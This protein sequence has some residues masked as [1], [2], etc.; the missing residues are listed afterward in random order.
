[1][2]NQKRNLRLLLALALLVFTSSCLAAGNVYAS[3]GG[4]VVWTQTSN[5][6][7]EDDYSYGV[8]VDSSG[9]F[10]VGYDSSSGDWQW[11]IEKRSLTNGSLIWSQT[12]DPGA[13]NDAA[14]DVASD[15][16]GLFVVGY[17]SSPGSSGNYQWRIEKR[18]LADG[19]LMWSQVSNPSVI[20]DFAYG[21]SIDGSGMYVVGSDNSPG[22]TDHQWRIEKRGLTDGSL[23]PTFG[24]G[25]VI[26]ENP[27]SGGDVA[28]DVTVDGS[29]MY[30]T[31]YD[32]S[33]GSGNS[34]WRIEKRSLTDGSLLWSQT[35]NPSDGY[36][37]TYGVAVDSSG[38]F[39]VGYDSSSGNLQW[40]IE[41]RRL[42]DGTLIWSQTSN[43][44]SGDHRAYGVAVHSSGVYIAGS[45][46]IPG[47]DE[48][49]IERRSA[50]DGTLTSTFGTGGI[51]QEDPSSGADS[52][53]GVAVDNSGVYVVGYDNSPGKSEWRIERR[54]LGLSSSKLAITVF[55]SS[56]IVGSWTS[57]CTV[58]R[59]DEFGNPVT[60]DSTIVNLAST[61]TGTGKKFSE[62]SGGAAVTSITI[63]DGS[64]TKDFY[65]FDDRAGSW[66]IS[67]SAA[68]L[69]SDN[70]P[71]TVSP[72]SGCVIATAAYGS[73]MAP[74]VSYMRHVRDDVIGS[75][76]VGRL[77]V[78]E[79]NVF[80]YSWSPPLAQFITSHDLARPIFRVLLLPLIV[81][82]HV[83]ALIYT[84]CMPVNA[85]FASLVAF[86]FAA[87]SS[88]TVYV[89]MPLMTLRMIH[90]KRFILS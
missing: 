66:S 68:G 48:W 74:E 19:S 49:R 78:G 3:P 84:S 14:S 67:V 61:S 85:E 54:N 1:M 41:K 81:T 60:S 42:A 30:V 73:D 76:E 34:E 21:V 33:L 7:S 45:D 26:M 27:S 47:N 28:S 37:V 87:V 82:V 6:S 56:V 17:D 12:S 2:T 16:S 80:Y 71:L 72:R 63:P 57:V 83:T 11:R 23:I 15:A 44:G 58:Q 64:S 10:V 29:G 53:R 22:L 69:T 55:P 86:L 24:T 5:P 32:Y 51:I 70:K 59:Q 79:W 62:T 88:S 13:G 50:A 36:D 38:V 46:R 75:N 90:R 39:V 20:A 18:N 4:E 89:V 31:G 40:R 8:A 52:S 43:P 9:V 77:L 25:G 35:S 65:Y